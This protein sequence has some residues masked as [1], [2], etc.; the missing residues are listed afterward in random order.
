MP[1]TEDFDP[2]ALNHVLA[3]LPG[4]LF[5][6]QEGI[7]YLPQVKINILGESLTFAVILEMF[8]DTDFEVRHVEL[9]IEPPDGVDF[10]EFDG[11]NTVAPFDVEVVADDPALTVITDVEF[12]VLEGCDPVQLSVTNFII[13]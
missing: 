13:P 11:T 10:V 8:S 5:D 9:L 12:S 6:L 7:L 2:D 1:Y 4:P 3:D